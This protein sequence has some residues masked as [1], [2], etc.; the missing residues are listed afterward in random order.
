MIWSMLRAAQYPTKINYA[1]C[2]FDLTFVH[3]YFTRKVKGRK[4]TRTWKNWSVLEAVWP[5]RDFCISIHMLFDGGDDY[6]FFSWPGHVFWKRIVPK[7]RTKTRQK[8][9]SKK[10]NLQDRNCKQMWWMTKL[11]RIKNNSRKTKSLYSCVSVHVWWCLCNEHLSSIKRELVSKREIG[12]EVD[13]GV[14]EGVVMDSLFENCALI[15]LLPISS[16]P[17]NRC[18]NL[19]WFDGWERYLWFSFSAARASMA[20]L[21]VS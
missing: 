4:V 16:F 20:F 10:N 12:S 9:N 19:I 15:S 7:T 13:L 14:I 5:K 1:R 11:P 3:R 8:T 21:L 18:E 2:F 17:L 6:H